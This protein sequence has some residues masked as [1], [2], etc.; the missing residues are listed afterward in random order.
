MKLFLFV[1]FIFISINLNASNIREI[2][3]NY[4]QKMKW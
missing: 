1:V 2:D 3:E 4:A